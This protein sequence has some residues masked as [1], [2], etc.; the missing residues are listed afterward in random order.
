MSEDT[1]KLI[2]FDL[3]PHGLIIAERVLV[4]DSTI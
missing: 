4:Y 3:F 1:C 2:E